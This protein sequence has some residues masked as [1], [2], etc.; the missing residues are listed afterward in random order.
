[1]TPHIGTG[2]SARTTRRERRHGR[3]RRARA[4]CKTQTAF[5][6]AFAKSSEDTTEETVRKV[7]H[8]ASVWI[9][10]RL[11]GSPGPAGPRG[12]KGDQVERVL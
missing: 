11:Q 9:F 6:Y 3:P 1:M 12:E 10:V 7:G 2:W 8:S 4:K 5:R